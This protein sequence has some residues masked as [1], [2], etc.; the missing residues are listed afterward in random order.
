METEESP[1]PK[2]ESEESPQPKID[3]ME[4]EESPQPKITNLP[5]YWQNWFRFNGL[6]REDAAAKNDAS[7]TAVEAKVIG[8]FLN[9][10]FI[11]WEE[12]GGKKLCARMTPGKMYLNGRRNLQTIFRD[13]GFRSSCRNRNA[14]L[15]DELAMKCFN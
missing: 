8:T 7:T 15:N 6:N 10:V 13:S 11:S 9:G 14:I 2:A 12:E 3:K 4:A 5:H 1:Q